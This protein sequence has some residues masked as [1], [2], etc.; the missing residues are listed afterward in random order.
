MTRTF[1]G[2]GGWTEEWSTLATV[3]AAI[4]P[5]KMVEQVEAGKRTATVTHQ[6]RVRYLDGIDEE[7]RVVFGDRVF[8]VISVLNVEE[9]NRTLDLMCE[10]T[11]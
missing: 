5:K 6:I 9:R 8:E 3:R 4:W 10:E 7:C 2:M 1:D 11:K